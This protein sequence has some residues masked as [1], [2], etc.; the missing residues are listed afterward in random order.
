MIVDTNP[1]VVSV[2]PQST[3][4]SP[5][6]YLL[7]SLE[8]TYIQRLKANIVGGIWHIFQTSYSPN[9]SML[10]ITV[11]WSNLVVEMLD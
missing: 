2:I 5:S 11:M 9:Y 4:L 1:T 6:T 7:R 8:S 10:W 3:Y